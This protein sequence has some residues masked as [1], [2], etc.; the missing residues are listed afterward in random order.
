VIRPT[1][2]TDAPAVADVW[3]RSRLAAVPAIPAPVHDEPD[4]RR[5]V[6]EVLVP[7]GGTWVAV[8]EDAVVAMVSLSD[9]WIDQLYVDPSRQGRGIGTC[10]VD[11]A[12]ARAPDGLDL[13]TFQTNAGA[14][15]FYERHGFTAVAWTEGDNEEGAPDVRYRWPGEGRPQSASRPR[16]SP[17]SSDQVET[18]E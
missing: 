15:R 4:V 6:A 16:M 13:W 8:E 3:W 2:P 1:S 17:S 14:R 7:K 9:G 18:P 5:W 11:F 10:L 12:K